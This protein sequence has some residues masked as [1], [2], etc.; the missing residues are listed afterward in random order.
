MPGDSFDITVEA[1]EGIPVLEIASEEL[2][3][4]ATRTANTWRDNIRSGTGANGSHGSPWVN[5]GEA[6]NDVTISPQS[7]GALEYTVGGDVI[8]L[9]VAETGRAPG[10]MPPPEPIADWMREALGER[11]PDPWPI[12]KHIEREGIEGFAPGRGAFLEHKDEL[13]KRVSR[14]VDE[15][16]DEQE[17]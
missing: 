17:I 1:Y 2:F 14:R 13:S 8:Q 15:A 5:T 9:A 6:A 11:D 7:E 16:L 10:S 4:V 12:Q 3:K